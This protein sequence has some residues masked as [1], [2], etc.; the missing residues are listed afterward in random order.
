M[1]LY[2]YMIGNFP[3]IILGKKKKKY[4]GLMLRLIFQIAMALLCFGEFLAVGWELQF[5]IRD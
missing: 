3:R 2:I 4:L 5:L 1:S